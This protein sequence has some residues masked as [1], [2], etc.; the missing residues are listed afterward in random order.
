MG[1]SLWAGRLDSRRDGGRQ[2]RLSGLAA[3]RGELSEAVGGRRVLVAVQRPLVDLFGVFRFRSSTAERS[4]S[5]SGCRA[6]VDEHL[7]RPPGAGQGDQVSRSREEWFLIG[8]WRDVVARASAAPASATRA[9]HDDYPFGEGAGSPRL[10]GECGAERRAGVPRPGV[11][12]GSNGRAQVPHCS[13]GSPERRHRWGN[14]DR[15]R[16]AC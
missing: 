8:E 15:E 10:A 2:E 13:R 7:R 14:E 16:G 1:P 3:G 4:G 5:T 6:D 9:V 11:E 12:A